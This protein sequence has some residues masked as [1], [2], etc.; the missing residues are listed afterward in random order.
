VPLVDLVEAG[1]RIVIADKMSAATPI[2][3]L[4]IW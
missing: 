4:T 3:S 2:C 1:G